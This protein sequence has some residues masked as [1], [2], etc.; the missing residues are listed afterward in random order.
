MDRFINVEGIDNH[1]MEQH[2]LV[3]ARGVTNSN[4][5]PIILIMH[6]YAL[7]GK[8]ISIHSS[9]QM[10]WY[11][12]NV[13]DKSVKVGGTQGLNPGVLFPMDMQH[14]LWAGCMA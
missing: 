2:L 12:I 8:G 5:G 3:T 11:Q 4:R 10:E 7:A 9:P 1:M 6:Q 13:N 14:G